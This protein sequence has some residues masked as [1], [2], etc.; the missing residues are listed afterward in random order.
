MRNLTTELK[1][2][3]L[4]LSGLGIIVYSSVVVTGW[5]PGVTDTYTLSMYF[6][7][8][9]GLLT[10]SPVQVAGV[11]VGQVSDIT[12]AEGQAKVSVA[13]YKRFKIYADATATIKSL[14]ILGDKYVELRPG[15]A[16]QAELRDGDTIVLV[17]PG[18]DLDSLVQNLS[19]ILHDIK[20]VTSALRDTLG[21][22]A[23]RDRLDNILNQI[24]KA[25]SD[26]SRITD[27]TNRQ[28]D[29][30]LANLN[31]FTGNLDKITSENRASLKQTLANFAAFS[32]DLKQITSHNRDSLDR[33]IAG[34]DTF[35]NALAKDGP[36][37]TGDLKQILA[38]NKKS[39][40]N[41]ITSLD[42]SFSKLDQTMTNI[43]SVSQKL[44]RGE[45]TIGKLLNDETT[46]DQLNSALTGLNK[47]LTDADRIKLDIGGHVEYLVRQS[48]YKSYLDIRLQPLK[49]RYYML[50]LVDNPRGSVTKRTVTDTVGGVSTTT[51]ETV[52]EDKLQ[53]S[54][55]VGQRYYDTVIKGGLMENTFGVGVEQYFGSADN[56]RI[57]LDVWDFGND[58]GPH[59][60]LTGYWRFFSNAFLVLGGDDLA[61]KNPQFRDAFFGI[62]LH[63]NEDSLK[64]LFSSLPIGNLSK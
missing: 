18:S 32:D 15:T 4:I 5:R 20:S 58:L 53:L 49:D 37:I 57:G 31:R 45:G 10:G 59:L 28:I 60:K 6:T 62:G 14:G 47:F 23:G 41:A 36:S 38:E 22:E 43:Q 9:S 35:T 19:D 29:T 11:K 12:L 61:S 2:G 48:D 39:L 24:A 42:A 3:L 46:V 40:N 55:L 8:A 25:T 21:G 52:T 50:Q 64:P 56:Y 13:I 7:N 16:S 34:L 54:L 30:I 26:I 51:N 44:D 1:V 27:A 63:F 33:I 17:L